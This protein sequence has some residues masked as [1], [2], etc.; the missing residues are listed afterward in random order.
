MATDFKNQKR[1]KKGEL[2]ETYVHPILRN[3]GWNVYTTSEDEDKA[4]P[5]DCFITKMTKDSV[6]TKAVEVKT[7][8]ELKMY[9]SQGLDNHKIIKYDIL[10]KLMPVVI[11]FIDE[12]KG[13]ISC[14]DYTYL[15]EPST[16]FDKKAGKEVTYPNIN[17]LANQKITAYDATKLKF[18]ANLT[19]EQKEALK[20][21][22]NINP[23]YK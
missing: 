8:P 19:E 11:F 21:L 12:D 23:A 1:T 14:C 17:I 13:T 9:T 15:K 16:V 7:R 4:H 22:S 18:V 2:G 3:K 10:E 5:I 6:Q 20:A